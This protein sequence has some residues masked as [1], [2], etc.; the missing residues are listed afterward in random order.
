LELLQAFDR[1]GHD[2][3]DVGIGGY[4]EGHG[5]IPD[6]AVERAIQDKAPYATRVV[7]QICFDARTTGAWAQGL[8]DKGVTLPVYVGMPG[9]VNRQKL[10]RISAGIGLGRSARFLRKQQGL[11]RF[12]F[13]G[14]YDATRLARRLGGAALVGNLC[15]LHIFTFNELQ[16]TERWR[17]GMRA[18]L[19]L[20]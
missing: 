13:P 11:W 15:G 5:T 9:P 20:D 18:R 8:V 1:V 10:I 19:G 14:A 6:S 12:L 4:P 3:K 16:G 2:L 7:T 17:R